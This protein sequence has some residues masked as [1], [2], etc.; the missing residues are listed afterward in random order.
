MNPKTSQ[1]IKGQQSEILCLS[2]FCLINFDSMMFC[3]C[4]PRTTY[5]QKGIL[6]MKHEAFHPSI[7]YVENELPLPEIKKCLFFLNIESLY[8][9][10]SVTLTVMFNCTTCLTSINVQEHSYLARTV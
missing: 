1:A 5:S 4:F 8:A 7:C 10:D 3:F 6:K 9:F 2:Y